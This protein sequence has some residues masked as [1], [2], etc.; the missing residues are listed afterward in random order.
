MGE[1]R[2]YLFQDL[3]IKQE[4]LFDFAELYQRLFSWFEVMGYDFYEKGYE[5]HDKGA[6]SD[7]KIFWEATKETDDYTKFVIDVNFF[8]L[9]FTKV[10]V[11]KDGLKF[12]TNKGSMEIRMNAYIVHDKKGDMEK[13]FTS[14]GRT[15]YEKFI[16]KRRLEDQEVALYNESHLLMDEIK[17]FV[18]M[19]QF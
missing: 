12:K 8:I 15:I 4:A 13:R 7:I 14:T 6:G 3:K 9:G 5:K 18:S 2:I 19:H 17:A 11:E 16:A 1:R 10:E